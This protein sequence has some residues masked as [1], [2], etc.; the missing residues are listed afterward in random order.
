MQYSSNQAVSEEDEDVKT[1]LSYL[2]NAQIHNV[3]TYKAHTN[4]L[5]ML[6]NT[7]ND[8]CITDGGAD[9]HV[10]G[11]TWLPLT[12]ISGPNVKFANVTGFDEDSA[13]KF[14]LPIVQ[15]EIKAISPEGKTMMLRAKHLIFNP[16]CPH[17]L[18]STYQMR[19][20][21]L[22]VD[23]V[24][25]RHLKDVTS[26]GTHSIILPEM[27]RTI[28]LTTRAALST[29]TVTKPTLK[30]YL[31]TPE[32]EILDIAIEHWNPQEHNE[33]SLEYTP[34]IPLPNQINKIT[35]NEHLEKT[36][37]TFCDLN[38]E[39]DQ[40]LPC[41]QEL[42][43]NEETFYDANDIESDEQ[44][45][46]PEINRLLHLGE[47]RK[48]RGVPNNL[49]RLY[50]AIA[51]I[52]SISQVGQT[53]AADIPKNT[54]DTNSS[55]GVEHEPKYFDTKDPYLPEKP[56]KVLHLSIDYQILGEGVKGNT[57]CFMSTHK[58]NNLLSDLDYKQLTGN[59]EVFN[60]L[61]HALTTVEKLQK[62]EAI[63]PRLAWKPIEVIKKTL[64]NTTQ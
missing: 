52:L 53:N 7:P 47:N 38:S 56:G 11:R 20:L 4:Y 63:Q 34:P 42:N 9:S 8:L 14:G 44:E 31:D 27:D 41:I 37:D 30:E 5:A 49:S 22:I 25:K 32:E 50:K 46:T 64:E 19:E 35:Y 40:Y 15:D 23:D 45:D 16:T 33:E 48:E 1:I 2:S 60:T 29:F 28:H 13:K 59:S 39:D 24:S 55:I 43:L 57:E 3:R 6:V 18:L 36:I 51:T 54:T 17:T 62:I 10:G 12:A 61:A 26:N 21:G 58:V